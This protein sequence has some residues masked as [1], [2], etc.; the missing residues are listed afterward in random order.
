MKYPAR[1]YTQGEIIKFVRRKPN[2]K[3]RASWHSKEREARCSGAECPSGEL[4]V[5]TYW[6]MVLTGGIDIAG[7]DLKESDIRTLAAI[8]TD[9]FIALMEVQ[10]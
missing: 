10:D 7:I 1:V 9:G 5:K 2:G 3:G 8:V 4:A 6:D